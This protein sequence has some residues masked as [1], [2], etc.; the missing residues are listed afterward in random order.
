M[1]KLESCSSGG[2][3]TAQFVE[4]YGITFG[5]LVE[6]PTTEDSQTMYNANYRVLYDKRSDRCFSL[7]QT[8]YPSFI[9]IEDH[10]FIVQ[11]DSLRQEYDAFIQNNLKM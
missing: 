7:W 9:L 1:T 11:D 6:I 4:K 5:D 2:V 3:G 10:G 8:P